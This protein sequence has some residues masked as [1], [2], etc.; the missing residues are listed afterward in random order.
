MVNYCNIIST[1]KLLYVMCIYLILRYWLRVNLPRSCGILSG[2]P[3]LYVF[4][5]V[6]KL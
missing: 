1:T 6:N 2:L 5:Y 4:K 3:G